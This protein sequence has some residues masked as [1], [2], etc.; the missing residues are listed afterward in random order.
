MA[1][2]DSSPAPDKPP[3]YKTLR[4]LNP[5][6]GLAPA[7]INLRPDHGHPQLLFPSRGFETDPPLPS[8]F[9]QSLPLRPPK[10]H[11]MT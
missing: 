9:H 8:K 7:T 6:R 4:T 1:A 10:P 5:S 11:G 2:D 3:V